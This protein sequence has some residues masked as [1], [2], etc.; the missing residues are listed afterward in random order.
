[1]PANE[2]YIDLHFPRGGM[3]ISQAAMKTPSRPG[4]IG[5]DGRPSAVYTTAS[6]Q[7]VRSFDAI[8]NRYRGGTRFGQTRWLADPIVADWMIQSLHQMVA[9]RAAGVAMQGSQLGRVV[10]LLATCQGRH[11]WVEPNDDPALRV[12][13]ESTNSSG[14]SPPLSFSGIHRAS[15]LNQKMY[16]VDG[17]RYRYYTPI[18]HVIDAWTETTTDGVMPSATVDAVVHTCRLIA[19]YHGSIWLSGLIG[20]PQNWFASRVNDAHDFHYGATPASDP[21]KAVAG[22]NSRAGFIGDVVTAMMAYTDDEMLFG[23]NKTI[24]VMRGDPRTGGSIDLVT[25]S[26]GVAF[27]E[28][29]TQ[30]PQGNIYFMSN[31]GSI[32]VMGPRQKPE[33]L[34]IPVDQRFQDINTGELG[35][36]LEWNERAKGLHVI[37]STLAEA[38]RTDHHMFWE[39]S[40]GWCPDKFANKNHNALA[41][42]VLDGNGPADR[43][44]LVGGRDGYIRAFDPSAAD[45]DGT[46]I[47]SWV[48]IGPLMTRNFDDLKLQSLQA[49]L[50]EGSGTVDWSVHSGDTPEEALAADPENDGTWEAGRNLTELI[51]QSGHFI[52]IKLYSTN[53]WALEGI[54]AAISNVTSKIRMRG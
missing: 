33:K 13:T 27:G 43:V 49:I 22:N 4:P 9:V 7:N 40:N 12:A 28:A 23:G 11:F 3:D 50:A 2:R 38:T 24:Y 54:R 21:A 53:R 41:S 29:F 30:D 48:F 46:P 42:C 51:K 39:Q 14:T 34:S 18:T 6:S 19:T 36:R 20:D 15:P 5:P 17:S 16:Y 52:Y 10:E 45:D 44:V 37:M 1:M 26:I 35:V 31:T 25:S 47:E 8:A 32:Y